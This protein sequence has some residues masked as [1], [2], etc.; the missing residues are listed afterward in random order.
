MCLIESNLFD[1][2][3]KVEHNLVSVINDHLGL[4]TE[5]SLDYHIVERKNN[6]FFLFYVLCDL[7]VGLRLHFELWPD[8]FVFLSV[9]IVF[10]FKEQFA[11]FLMR[12]R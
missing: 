7:A 2:F 4:I 10:K 8:W 3:I 9:E 5:P 12:L 11:M 1:S 6:R